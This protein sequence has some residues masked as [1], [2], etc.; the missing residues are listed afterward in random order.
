MI[1]YVPKINIYYLIIFIIFLFLCNISFSYNALIKKEFKQL[2]INGN[3][4]IENNQIKNL[5]NKNMNIHLLKKDIEKMPFVESAHFGVILPNKLV[6]HI[7]EK[8]P[9]AKFI[10][11]NNKYYI[12]IHGSK[13][14]DEVKATN[15]YKVPLVNINYNSPNEIDSVKKLLIELNKTS[16][17]NL[18]DNITIRYAKNIE[19]TTNNNTIIYFGDLNKINYKIK[20]L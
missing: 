6:M 9:I 3:N 7:F 12:D 13:I 15:F 20:I 17:Y 8:Q 18:L 19:L 14:E 11:N 4:Y 16:I 2:I 1:K 5:Y 10:I